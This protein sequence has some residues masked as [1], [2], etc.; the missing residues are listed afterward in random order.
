MDAPEMQRLRDEAEQRR[1][2]AYVDEMVTEAMRRSYMAEFS[3]EQRAEM[4][5]SYREAIEAR[6]ERDR[7]AV[8]DEAATA[9]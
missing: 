1:H 5:Q 6:I 9:A 7:A 8:A 3:E 2:N 4:A